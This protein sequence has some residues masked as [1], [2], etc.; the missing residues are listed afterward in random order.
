MS[1]VITEKITIKALRH[2]H[3]TWA[4]KAIRSLCSIGWEYE[5]RKDKRC[6][7]IRAYSVLVDEYDNYRT[8][9]RVDEGNKSQS[10][11]LWFWEKQ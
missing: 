2:N 6:V 5:G 4:W 3:P 10:Y 11:A 1:L 8:E 7:E 9:W